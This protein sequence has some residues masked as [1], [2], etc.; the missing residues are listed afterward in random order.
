MKHGEYIKSASD[1]RGFLTTVL[2]KAPDKLAVDYRAPEYQLT[3]K[4]AFDVLREK[5]P[6]VKSRVKSEERMRILGEMLLISYEAYLTN[7]KKKACAT[8]QE[9][10]GIVWPSFAMESVYEPEA[11]TRLG[12]HA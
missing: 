6:T 4:L 8:L 11:K 2:L 5:L 1:Y 3:L 9:I 7:D 10:M 12:I